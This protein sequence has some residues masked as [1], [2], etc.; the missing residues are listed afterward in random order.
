MAGHSRGSLATHICIAIQYMTELMIAVIRA[1]FQLLQATAVH[2][3]DALSRRR[4]RRLRLPAGICCKPTPATYR[5]LVCQSRCP[6]VRPCTL[7]KGRPCTMQ[8]CA[9][10][11]AELRGVLLRAR[12]PAAT[13]DLRA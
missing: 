3:V 5:S 8:T 2:T 4:T 12:R 7:P 9:P 6:A 1:A 10:C 13:H 11:L